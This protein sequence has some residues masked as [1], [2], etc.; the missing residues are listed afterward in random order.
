MFTDQEQLTQLKVLSQDRTIAVM[1]LT[2]E[3]RRVSKS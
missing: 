1:G 3:E 2:E